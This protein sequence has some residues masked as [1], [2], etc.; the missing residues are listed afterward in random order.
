MLLTLGIVAA[1]TLSSTRPKLPSP[2]CESCGQQLVRNRRPGSEQLCRACRVARVSPEQHRR[3]AAQ[4]FVIIA[5]M[6]LALTFLLLYPFTGLIHAHLGDHGYPLAAIGLFFLLCIFL[7]G[8]LVLHCLLRMWRMSHP[9]YSLRI[10]RTCAGGIG[11]HTTLGPVSVDV[12]GADESGSMFEARMSLCRERFGSLIGAP[13]EPESPLRFF[14]FGKRSAFD[15]LFKWAFLY[16]GNL[17]GFY[18][19]WSRPTIAITTESPAHRLLDSERT[20]DSLIACFYLDNYRKTPAPLWVQMGIANVVACGGDRME[21][22][23][24]Q[25]E[26]A[27]GPDQGNIARG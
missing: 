11:E 14:V 13:F 12:F 26:V 5:V 24:A 16:V 15:A 3:L 18:V 25:S 6:L 1:C 20:V 10:A 21:A 17:D 7:A 27:R 23:A 9:G 19:R 4:G 2:R 8:T 22:C